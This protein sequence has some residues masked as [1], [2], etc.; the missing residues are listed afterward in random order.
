MAK[1]RNQYR[2]YTLAERTNALTKLAQNAGNAQ[3]TAKDTGIPLTTIITWK[4][5]YFSEYAGIEKKEIDDILKETW[6]GIKKLVN[7]DL[8]EDLI[9][10][11]KKEGKLKEVISAASVLIDKALLLSTIKASLSTL[12]KPIDANADHLDDE[13]EIQQMI[14]EEEAK[15]KRRK[16]N[17][18]V[19]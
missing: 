8:I 3:K 18:V 16:E 11:A 13:K 2:S 15:E 7:S 6:K 19:A 5:T 10:A 17:R 12:S 4:N 9:L 14:K 1:G